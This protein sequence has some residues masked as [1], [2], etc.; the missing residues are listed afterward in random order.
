[1][2]VYK[3]LIINVKYFIDIMNITYMAN[4]LDILHQLLCIKSILISLLTLYLHFIWSI[5]SKAHL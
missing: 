2:I 5:F 1:M 3:R 4:F